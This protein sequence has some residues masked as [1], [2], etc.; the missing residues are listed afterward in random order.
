MTRSGIRFRPPKVRVTAEVRWVFLRAFGPL[1]APFSE[2]LDRTKVIE[3][4]RL[5]SL[6]PRIAARHELERP[7]EEVGQEAA[8]AL[9]M[10]HFSAEVSEERR[11]RT[12]TYLAEI[13]APTSVPLVFLKFVALQ[14][15]G[16]L[17]PG[18][19]GA[20]DVDVL[21]SEDRAGGLFEMLVESGFKAA[22][23]PESEHQ[24]PPLCHPTHG[25]VEVHRLVPGV[26][27][28]PAGP[29]ATVTSLEQSGRLCPIR[30]WAGAC[31]IPTKDV[32]AAHVLVHGIAQ[33][34]YSPSA[35]PMARMLADLIDLGFVESAGEELARQAHRWI[36][37]DVSWEE[38]EATLMLVRL[39][40]EGNLE[41]LESGASDRPESLLWRHLVAG[42]LDASYERALRLHGVRSGLSDRSAPAA[43]TRNLW[44]T[45]FLT[46]GQVDAIY[47]RPRS[48][49]GYFGRRLCRPFD[50]VLR[51]S[52]YLYG[53]LKTRGR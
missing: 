18:C 51:F 15:A 26:R 45:V 21:V 19:R 34:G 48:P 38:V 23:F 2:E 53:F 44:Q 20:V 1:D 43:V 8:E 27:P 12:A 39:L 35:Y 22:D 24:L 49:L 52:K 33:H 6:S 29:S 40:A 17:R 36:A 50:L 14:L 5:F 9:L 25:S 32:L 10:D 31:A 28:D 7:A 30:H 37:R 16:A 46:R 4:S 13:V 47:G 41:G 11:L 3:L 42:M